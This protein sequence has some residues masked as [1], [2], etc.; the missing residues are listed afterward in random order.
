MPV[1]R[2]IEQVSGRLGLLRALGTH[3]RQQLPYRD[4][5]VE[6]PPE[7]EVRF[8]SSHLSDSPQAVYIFGSLRGIA[9]LSGSGVG[10]R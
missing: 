3:M 4:Q 8:D 2:S 1:L 9:S 10:A 5:G 6:V 7:S